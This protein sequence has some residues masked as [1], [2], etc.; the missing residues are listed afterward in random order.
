MSLNFL[1]KGMCLLFLFVLVSCRSQ[2]R[3]VSSRLIPVIEE[4]EVIEGP[5]FG[6]LEPTP[7][8]VIESLIGDEEAEAMLLAPIEA[9]CQFESDP[10]LLDGGT[11]PVN[12]PP[13]AIV[14]VS[15]S[16]ESGET[17]GWNNTFLYETE[18]K[19]LQMWSVLTRSDGG[20]P[21]AQFEKDRMVMSDGL[22]DQTGCY[23]RRAGVFGNVVVI[24]AAFNHD[25]NVADATISLS[26]YFEKYVA[27]I[28]N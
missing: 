5:L 24:V 23:A 18:E 8:P 25:G 20:F 19:A 14:W 12:P 27:L 13:D 2:V 28:D 16:Y 22:C 26:I 21:R 15:W 11:M 17:C 3:E 9:D 7:L 1:K 10:K 4:T 6:E